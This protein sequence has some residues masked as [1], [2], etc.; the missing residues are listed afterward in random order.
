VDA[1]NGPRD[2]HIPLVECS[3][4]PKGAKTRGSAGRHT[5][6]QQPAKASYRSTG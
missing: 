2:E 1:E 5:V 3:E 4:H 6:F